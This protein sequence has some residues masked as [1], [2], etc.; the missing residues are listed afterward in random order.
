[1][2]SGSNLSGRDSLSISTWTCPDSSRILTKII[3]ERPSLMNIMLYW[4]GGRTF[5]P[6]GIENKPASHDHLI[7]AFAAM[8]LEMILNPI[9]F[10]RSVIMSSSLLYL[11]PASEISRVTPW[12]LKLTQ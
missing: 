2:T 9:A 7:G 8:C 12:L 11:A 5:W 4:R 6:A 10:C 1:M 3:Q